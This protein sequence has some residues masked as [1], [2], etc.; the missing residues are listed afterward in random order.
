MDCEDENLAP[1]RRKPGTVYCC[2]VNCHNNVDS[3]KRVDTPITFHSFP[4]KW[5]ETARREA[6]ITAVRRKDPDGSPWQ[7]T[8]KTRICSAHFVDNC[9]SNIEGHPSYVPTIFPPVYRKKAPDAG[10]HKRWMQRKHNAVH[11][12]QKT[13]QGML[14]T[15][16]PEPSAL[17]DE[18]DQERSE[19]EQ[20]DILADIAS[21]APRLPTYRDVGT[22]TESSSHAG[23]LKMMLSVTDGV[24][25]MCQ[26]NHFDHVEQVEQSCTEQSWRRQCG[27]QGFATLQKSEQA[28]QDLCNVTLAVFTV[29]LNLLPEQRYRSSDV[30]R[31]DRLVLF[32]MKLKL[33]VSLRAFATLFGISRSTASRVFHVTLDYLSVKLQDWVFVPPRH[34]IREAMPECFK[35]QYPDCTFVIDCTEVRTEAPS[36]PEQQ[37]ELYS[38][39]K[40]TY[41][42]K[43]LVAITPDGMV[44]FISPAYGGRCSDSEITR[45]SG[46]LTLLKPN[47]VVLS[48]KGFPSIRTSV[49][50]QGAVLVMPPFNLGGGQLSVGDMTATFAIAQVRI[51]VER[52]IQRLKQFNILNNRVPLS[53][54][55]EMS[56]VMRV[57]SAL[58]NLQTPIIRS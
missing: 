32:L 37:H 48:D 47:D 44:A 55:P 12:L 21:A 40:G 52:A 20:L 27:F 3:A 33:G 9:V 45:H 22:E 35:R 10:R 41:T 5:Y 2:V 49:S 18:H 17:P 25:A 26:V 28:L 38:H 19:D 39:Y 11:S 58:V 42:L 15:D 31:E 13:C 16:T 36:Q 43:W 14:T 34:C 4:G 1:K 6:W 51:H 23:S 46:F 50:D 57:C 7:P 53:L 56:K 29:L 24:N 30:T 54:I 8:K